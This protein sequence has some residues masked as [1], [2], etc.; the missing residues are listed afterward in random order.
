[1]EELAK[2]FIGK[3][4]LIYTVTGESVSVKGTVTEVKDG[5]LVVENDGNRQIVNLEYIT[6]IQEW[7]RNAKGKKKSVLC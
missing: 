2:Q 1:M 5:W 4:C 6:R 3:D 7:P